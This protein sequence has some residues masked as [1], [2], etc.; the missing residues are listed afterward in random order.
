MRS[1]CRRSIITMSAPASPAFMSVKISTPKRSASAGSK[2]RGA[3]SRTRAPIIDSSRR[4][5]RATRECSTSPQIATV[6]FSNRPSRRLMVS[7]SS[8]AWVGCSCAPSPALT[9]LQS[10][11]RDN[12]SAAPASGWRTT[13]MSGR[14][15]FKVLAVSIR[16][17]PLD[18][19]DVLTL[20]LRVSAPSRL[21]A[22]SKLDWVRV[23]ASKNRL[24]RVRPRSRAVF[25]SAAR[26][27]TT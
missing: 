2:G 10:S 16:V 7:A 23:L 1:I 12:S 5:D 8:S 27:W 20:I 4:F 15:A 21:A 11:L 19:E 9:T 17:S 3:T 25:L 24:M 14:M 13:N 18:T 6:R 22:S 26:P